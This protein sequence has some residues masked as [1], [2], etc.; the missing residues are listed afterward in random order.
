M[1]NKQPY[2]DSRFE[3][4]VEEIKGIVFLFLKNQEICNIRVIW[5]NDTKE[6]T[7]SMEP[8]LFINSFQYLIQL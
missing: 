2:L 3:F 1:T 6:L 4:C 5:K 7:L 8:G